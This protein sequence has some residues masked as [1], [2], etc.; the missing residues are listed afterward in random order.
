MKIRNFQKESLT[1]PF[2]GEKKE[3]KWKKF[4]Y[5]FG[6]LAVIA[7]MALLIVTFSNISN[8]K[9]DL[10]ERG[11]LNVNNDAKL[12]WAPQGDRIKTR[13]ALTLDP[14]KVWQEYP[15][16]QL[17]RS[18]WLNLN[19]LWQYAVN[20]QTD[21]APRNYDGYILVPFPIESSLSGVMKT[22]TKE[23]ALWYYK[24]I[25]IPSGWNGKNVL[26][27]FGAV[28][29]RCE[30]YV[31][32][33]KAG[34]HTGGY[35]YFYFDITSYLKSGKNELLIRVIDVSD[36]VYSTWGKY[37]PVGKQSITPNGIWYTPASGIWQTLWLEPV[38]TQ[39]FENVEV[40]NDY[41]NKQ[42]KMTFKVPNNQRL[43][44]QFTVKYNG[45]VVG[46]T[47]GTSNQEISIKLSDANFHAWSPTDPNMYTI[48]AQL[49]T[50]SGEVLDTISSY[51]TIRVVESKRDSRNK[52]RIFLNNKPIF[53]IGPLDQGYWP[54][55]LYTPPS[56]EAMVY[57]IQK[58]K[59]LGFNTIRKH[60]KTEFFRYYYYCDK[61]GM[62]VWQDMPSGNVDGSGSWDA[63]SMNGGSDTKRTQ[64][65]K[66]NYYKEWGEI[67]DNLKFF[68]CI[69]IWTP[70]NEA[71][72]QFDTE[73]VV[74]FTKNHDNLR[75]IN[76]ASG[77]NHRVTGNF[78][79][80]HSY[81]G[82]N[83]FLKHDNL[84]NVIGE[85]GGTGLEIKGH[86]WKDDNWGYVVVKDKQE[87]TDRYNEY[88]DSL[89]T[90]V[91]DGISA[92]IYTQT[93]DVEGEI[94][95]LLTYDRDDTKCYDT[96]RGY[97]QKIIDSLK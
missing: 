68:Q 28:D 30:V 66:D 72:G 1:E 81:P 92:A 74:E 21:S 48:T 96:I 62:M 5:I 14:E 73:A 55:G 31:N 87:L 38:N 36:T 41:Y 93:T 39:H 90:M 15:R 35:T 82:P 42:I 71:W 61:M 2:E 32:G 47:R 37:Q 16:P 53:N 29:W 69:I 7:M 75:L 26:L 95:G 6:S 67:I 8:D 11:Y 65:S 3:S 78:L 51:T 54:D 22:F 27:N 44:V 34:E 13:W 85:Y 10:V 17:E 49:L 18:D 76:A 94:N 24:E 9:K 33:N 63:G 43:P 50:D 57:D 56:E 60:V 25:E 45:N 89:I 97:N 23:D 70:F 46:E 79:D 77:G 64:E 58:L 88:I 59:D 86:T 40:N 91:P 52:L 4:T 83:Y 12:K 80:L 19:G 84:I 20:K